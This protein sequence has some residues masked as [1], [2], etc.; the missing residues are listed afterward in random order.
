MGQYYLKVPQ[1]KG[2]FSRNT[3][4]GKPKRGDPIIINLDSSDGGGTHWV[5]CYISSKVEYFDSFG[6]RP[7]E[8]VTSF[9]NKLPIIHNSTQYQNLYSILCGYFC[10]YFTNER[11]NN[12]SA[13]DILYSLSNNTLSNE[14]FLRD[15]LKNI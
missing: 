15:Y 4:R 1:F 2:I 12:H 10:L 6:L 3:L 8:E 9:F 7:S 5:A 13:Y 14:S 11:N